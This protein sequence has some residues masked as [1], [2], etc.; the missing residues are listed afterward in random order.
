MEHGISL[1]SEFFRVLGPGPVP[2]LI[3]GGFWEVVGRLF[4][5]FGDVFR[6]FLEY[7]RRGFLVNRKRQANVPSVCAP[8]LLLNR[9]SS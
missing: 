8:L 5:G 2:D 1:K 9:I 7:V 3:L 6:R 4:G